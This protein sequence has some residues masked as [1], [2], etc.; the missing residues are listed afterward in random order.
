MIHESK[1]PV[2]IISGPSGVGKST[3]IHHFI[4]LHPEFVLARSVTTREK[5]NDDDCYLYVDES[6]FDSME[7]AG[8]FLETDRYLGVSYGTPRQELDRIYEE[9]KIP[10]LDITYSGMKN[11]KANKGLD[12]KTIFLWAPPHV[13]LKRIREREGEEKNW[14]KHASKL[15]ASIPAIQVSSEYDF[16][17][18]TENGIIDDTVDILEKIILGDGTTY[19]SSR[20]KINTAEY[21][22]KTKLTIAIYFEREKRKR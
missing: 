14:Y 18:N 19:S 17:V 7:L 5:R 4:A 16:L 9:N 20:E 11:L 22:Y 12:A 21:I 15:S 13:L 10:I 1:K 2:I 3:V 8:E 6:T